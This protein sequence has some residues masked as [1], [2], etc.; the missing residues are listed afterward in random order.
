MDI[1]PQVVAVCQDGRHRFSKTP[2]LGIRVI[3]GSGVEG[4]AHSGAT[5]QHRHDRRYAPDRP[6]LRQ[7]HLIDVALF[8]E[9][10]AIGFD[11]NPGDLGENI[12]CTGIDL[13]ELP[14]GTILHVGSSARLQLTGLR[15]P[16]VLID[17]FKPGL[18]EGVESKG[19]LR[20]PYLRRG[21]MSR[22]LRTGSIQA[23]DRIRIE[24]P[25]HPHERLKNV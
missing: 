3:A 7:V 15:A 12:S 4:D 16:C 22:V 23:S 11:L 21:V 2:A 8:A 1:D 19:D 13:T 25:S 9:L 5:T 24:Y 10:Y 6:N 17:R 14:T 20:K 18:R